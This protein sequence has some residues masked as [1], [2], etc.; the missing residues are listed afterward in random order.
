M[1][2]AFTQRGSD[3]IEIVSAAGGVP[4]NVT[5]PATAPAVAGSTGLV[6]GAAGAAPPSEAGW[7]PPQAAAANETASAVRARVVE[8]MR[9]RGR[10]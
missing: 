1:A 2:P 10:S 8:P 3:D 7:P 5:L 9:M 6:T 4:M